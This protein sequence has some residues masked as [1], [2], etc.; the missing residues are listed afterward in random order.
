M[1]EV[2]NMAKIE[3]KLN[4]PSE[5]I[6]PEQYREHYYNILKENKLN[7]KSHEIGMSREDNSLTYIYKISGRLMNMRP[8]RILNSFSKYGEKIIVNEREGNVIETLN[9]YPDSIKLRFLK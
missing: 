2:D 6:T 5:I 9:Y 8:V 1:L 4:N 7:I 3:F